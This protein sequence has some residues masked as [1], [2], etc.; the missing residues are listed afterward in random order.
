MLGRNVQQ[1]PGTARGSPRRSRTAKAS[2]ISRYATKSRCACERGGWGRLSEDGPGHYNPDPSEG[3]WGGGVMILHGGVQSSRRPDTERDNRCDDEAHEE[4]MQTGRRTADAGSRLKS[5][6]TQKGSARKA[7]LPAVLGKTRRTD[8]RGDRGNVG[9]IRSPIRASIPPDNLHRVRRS[10]QRARPIRTSIPPRMTVVRS[11]PAWRLSRPRFPRCRR[12]LS[13]RC[14]CA[15]NVC[16]KR[17]CNG[18]R[19][20]SGVHF[21]RAPRLSLSVLLAA[22]HGTEQAGR[23]ISAALSTQVSA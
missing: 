12:R 9:I 19:H 1:K 7:S 5:R 14:R 3:P 20:K 21:K 17:R 6:T 4:R 18:H 15:V 10:R 13:R 16:L 8:D 22:R 11:A 2:R 23:E